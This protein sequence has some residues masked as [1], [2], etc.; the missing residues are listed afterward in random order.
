MKL[1][2][3]NILKHA[4][5]RIQP[6]LEDYL[7]VFSENELRLIRPRKCYQDRPC[8]GQ[9]NIYEKKYLFY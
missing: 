6:F 1:E 7:K 5:L 2:I 4:G 8:I 9:L 3:S